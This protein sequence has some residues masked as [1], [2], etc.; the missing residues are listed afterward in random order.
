MTQFGRGGKLSPLYISPF[1]IIERVGEVAYRLA[2]PP[3][4]SSVH[5]VFYVSMLRKYE[6]DA[7]HILE[8]S[9]L[10]LEAD[11]SY[12][13]RAIQILDRRE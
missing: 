8:W 7:S 2:L 11:V 4:L 13:E 10:D 6:S 1:D 5:G 9:D 12:E 3:H